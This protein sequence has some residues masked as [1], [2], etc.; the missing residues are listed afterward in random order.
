MLARAPLGRHPR[1]LLD[2]DGLLSSA[3]FRP[4]SVSLSFIPRSPGERAGAGKQGEVILQTHH[5]EH[6]LLQTLLYKGYDAFAEQ[7]AG[8]RQTMQLP[9]WIS[10]VLIRAEDHN[11]QQAPLFFTAAAH[12]LQASPLADES[13]GRSVRFRRSRPKRRLALAKISTA[14]FAARLATYR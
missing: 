14:S 6:P 1:L 8:R 2:V 4:Q 13:Y 11:N 10:H 12:L 9:P 5:P 3:D 7:G